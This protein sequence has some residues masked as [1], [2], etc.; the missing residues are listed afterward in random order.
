[1]KHVPEHVTSVKGD[2]RD[3]VGEAQQDVHPHQ[4]KEEMGEQEQDIFTEDGGSEPVASRHEGFFERV[5]G[6]PVQLKGDD[7]NRQHVKR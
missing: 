2:H 5:N 4:P 7:Q 1:M 6:D 3:Q